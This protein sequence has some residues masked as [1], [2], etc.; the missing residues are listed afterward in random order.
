MPADTNQG[1]GII[2]PPADIRGVIDKTAQFVAK[3]GPDFEQRVLSEQNHAKFAF[4]LPD[5][6]YRAYYEHKVKE[7]QTGT[8]EETKPQ[9]PQAIIEQQQKEE[10]KKQ[11]KEQLKALT[12]GS[13]R[14]KAVKPPP[15]DQFII[16]HPFIAPIDMDI[17]KL[18]AQFV[19]RNGQKFLIGL[20]QRENK[21]PQFDFLKP[22]H[23]L[24]G[25]FTSL[26]DSYTKCMMPNK[27]EVEKL[28]KYIANPQ[29]VMDRALARFAWDEQEEEKRQNRAEEE[30]EEKEQMAQIDWHDFIVVETIAF[31]A[32][33]DKLQLAA[34]LDVTTGAPSGAPVPLGGQGTYSGSAAIEKPVEPEEPEEPQVD[35]AA[36]KREREAAER[37]AKEQELR[38][39]EDRERE[40]REREQRER[41]ERERE[42]EAMQ[43]EPEPDIPMPQ[44]DTEMKV[45]KDYVRMKKTGTQR[46]MQRCPITGQLIPA[47]EMSQHLKILLLD[48]KWKH[49]KDA[50]VERARKESAFADDVEANLAA[51][52]AKRPDLF[53]SVDEQIREA[54]EAGA[55][56]SAREAG[57]DA[58]PAHTMV[59]QN[60]AGAL[61]AGSAGKE[62]G[63][64]AIGNAAA[65]A[66]GGLAALGAGPVAGVSTINSRLPQAA[67]AA[68]TPNVVPGNQPGVRPSLAAPTADD[69][70]DDDDE[71]AAKRQRLNDSSL[72]PEQQWI[73]ANPG[74]VNVLMQVQLG[75]EG[76]AAGV[77]AIIPLDV[78]VSMKVQDVKAMLLPRVAGAG[79]TL[80][81]MKLKFRNFFLENAASLAA[82]NI[83]TG[84]VIELTKKVRGGK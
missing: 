19:A 22:T 76:L 63:A 8:V 36:E 68:P 43:E 34:P 38:E 23:A 51:F 47:E 57:A 66:V 55:E 31:T 9:V 29:E 72:Q 70:D 82:Y 62:G 13:K 56:A 64:A 17:I 15:A 35:L 21:N 65:A 73:A 41:E 49:Q 5:N 4:L 6:P 79:V 71:P 12:D 45:R 14:K 42:E 10:A 40:E 75:P 61:T 67:L 25:Y 39:R 7:F 28:K 32:E 59:P 2:Y 27:E 52:V 78:S 20:T 18:T 30:K 60:T 74:S 77:P 46:T 16:S 3:C 1:V 44:M 58:G 54:A 80:P 69:D 83:G 48:P 53:G 26:V 24:F 84:A 50:L 33:D 11:K 81:S 37:A